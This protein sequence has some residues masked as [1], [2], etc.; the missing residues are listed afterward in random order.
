MGTIKVL[1]IMF[2]LA[3]CMIGIILSALGVSFYFLNS[4]LPPKVKGSGI[5][6][7]CIGDSVTFGFGIKNRN[8]NSYPAQL[9]QLLGEEY[10]V[11]NYGISGRTV[12]RSADMPY[13]DTKLYTLSLKALPDIVLIMLGTNDTKANNWNAANYEKDLIELVKIYKN[14]PNNPTVY[15]LKTCAVFYLLK[16]GEKRYK[17]NKDIIKNDV[18]RIIEKVAEIEK[19]DTIDVFSATE[20]HPEYY[21]DGI[22]PNIQGCTIIAE[23]VHSALKKR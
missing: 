5:K 13:V 23:T 12:I 7:A 8:K 6:V 4:P 1:E 15:I 10:Q 20:D 3:L 17:I 9:Q 16:N 11:L 22:H 18:V 14:L 2:R 21:I 19:V